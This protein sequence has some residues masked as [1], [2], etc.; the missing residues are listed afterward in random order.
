MDQALATFGKQAQIW[1]PFFLV[2]ARISLALREDDG[3]HLWYSYTAFLPEVPATYEKLDV[4]TNTIRACRELVPIEDASTADR[5]IAELLESPG[6]VS[7]DGLDVELAP[8]T[9][10]LSFEYE[11]LHL[12]RFAGP[13]RLPSLTMYWGNQQY[14][15][16]AETKQLDQELQLHH[17]PFDGF[18]DLAQAMVIPVSFD[19]LNKRRFS[20]LVLLPPVALLFDLNSEPRSVL[21]NGELSL[22]LKAHPA[23]EADQLRLGIKAFRQRGGPRPVHRG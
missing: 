15:T 14:R 23:L 6:R 21:S 2:R 22:V 3:W 20:E 13:S 12:N 4:R 18:A 16:F 7:I 10:H 9:L 17:T 19:D 5:M 1:K 11:P 8:S